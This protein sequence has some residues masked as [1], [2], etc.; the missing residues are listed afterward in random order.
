MERPPISR[1]AGEAEPKERVSVPTEAN[2]QGNWTE[3]E[4]GRLL[5]PTIR[6]RYFA[7]KTEHAPEAFHQESDDL[8]AKKTELTAEEFAKAL[9]EYDEAVQEIFSYTVYGPAKD[10]ELHTPRDL[11]FSKGFRDHGTVFQDAAHKD[12]APLTSR[13]KGII[14]AHEKLHSVM[15]LLTQ[16]ERKELSPMRNIGAK[17]GYG[18]KSGADELLARMGQLKN[19]FGFKGDEEFTKEHLD[20]ARKHYVLDTGLDNNMTELLV[21]IGKNEEN[22]KQFIA[23]M[24]KYAC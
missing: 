24:N 13:Q 16:G 6:A 20:Y 12:G 8:F 18:E 9:Q 15:R 17:I 3:V 14:E 10:F 1:H 19:Y 22:S 4:Y 7:T 2:Y 21:A 23:L 5:D 11:G